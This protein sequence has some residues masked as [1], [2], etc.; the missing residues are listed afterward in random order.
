MHEARVSLSLIDSVSSKF[1]AS[2]VGERLLTKADELTCRPEARQER[3]AVAGSVGDGTP[4]VS[5]LAI[6]HFVLG[7]LYLNASLCITAFDKALAPAD[8][9]RYALA[10]PIEKLICGVMSANTEDL[11]NCDTRSASADNSDSKH[12]WKTVRKQC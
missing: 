10:P 5:S 12:L 6:H 2:W 1:S 9:S 11:S 4:P 8:R 7:F 3:A